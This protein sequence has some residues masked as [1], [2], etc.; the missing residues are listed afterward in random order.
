MLGKELRRRGGVRV[1]GGYDLTAG[2]RK[3]AQM[4]VEEDLARGGG[5]GGGSY[6]TTEAGRRCDEP[7]GAEVD[8]DN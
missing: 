5:E 6:R 1:R 2:S 4:S 7:T 3:A 8:F